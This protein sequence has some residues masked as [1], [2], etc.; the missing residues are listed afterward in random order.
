MPTRLRPSLKSPTSRRLPAKRRFKPVEQPPSDLVEMQDR[1]PERSTEWV[2]AILGAPTRRYLN[3]D[4]ASCRAPVAASPALA[5]QRVRMR[6]GKFRVNCAAGYR[7]GT[8]RRRSSAS[9]RLIARV[10]DGWMRCTLIG[11]AREL[12]TRATARS[13]E[14]DA[15]L[16]VVPCAD[17]GK[18]RCARQ[19]T[20]THVAGLW[21]R[22]PMGIPMISSCTVSVAIQAAP[23]RR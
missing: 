11:G 9:S 6:C 3:D 4:D 16:M 2:R 19:D 20:R 5:E 8:D 1:Q 17:A 23:A 21:F 14:P 7:A 22:K 12:N 18:G 15:L 10:S 13:S